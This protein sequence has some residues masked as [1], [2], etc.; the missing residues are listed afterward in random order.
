MPRAKKKPSSLEVKDVVND[1]RE[2]TTTIENLEI[3]ERG[4][5][6]AALSLPY[7]YFRATVR[8]YKHL[9]VEE[10][11][12]LPEKYIH[13]LRM[14]ITRKQQR[15]SKK[16][17]LWAKDIITTQVEQ[18]LAD[19]QQ[20]RKGPFVVATEDEVSQIKVQKILKVT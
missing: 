15:Q 10:C 17:G 14:A 3:L 12:R 2:Q 19:S 20:P 18:S 1:S 7:N 8:K 5:I 11:Q 16:T 4:E 9:L 13:E 6:L